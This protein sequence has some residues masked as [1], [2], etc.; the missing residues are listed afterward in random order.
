MWLMIVLLIF[1][2]SAAAVALFMVFDQRDA[3]AQDAQA[4][5]QAELA[6]PI[7]LPIDPF[8]VNLAEDEYGV[9]LLYTGITLKLKSEH[10]KTLLEEYMPQV[11][12][13]LLSLFTGKEA[14]E[15]ISP[16]GKQR[17]TAEVIEA[18]EAPM[19]DERAAPAIA[20]VLF[21]EF[22]VQ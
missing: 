10:S 3:A 14:S 8:T 4:A 1:S 19:D 6:P 5:Q 15:L 7:F 22:I 12:S 18:L 11:R 20:D 17:L 13:R 16:S 2:S 21:T 9:R